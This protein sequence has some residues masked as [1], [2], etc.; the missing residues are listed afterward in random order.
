[1]YT[2]SVRDEGKIDT[3]NFLFI[4][5][6]MV[7]ILMVVI[8]VLV[9]KQL[10]PELPWL[11]SLPWGEAQLIEKKY[12]AGTLGGLAVLF[13]LTRVLANWAGKKDVIVRTTVI[14]GGLMMILLYA[15]GFFKVLSIFVSL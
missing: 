3:Q 14:T 11:Y 5:G 9:W 8:L 12:F 4:I 1:M 13:I 10:P 7:I 15:A 6:V 2:Q